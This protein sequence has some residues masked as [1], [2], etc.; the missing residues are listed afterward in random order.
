M[1]FEDRYPCNP[2]DLDRYRCVRVSGGKLRFVDMY[3]MNPGIDSHEKVTVW[4]LADPDSAKWTLEREASFSDIWADE[5]YEVTGLPKRTPG[6]A[7]IHPENPDVAYFFLA[8]HLFGVDLHARKVVECEVCD[9]Q[10]VSSSSLHA[11]ELPEGHSHQVTLPR[12]LF[13]G[14]VL[15]LLKCSSF[16]LHMHFWCLS[17]FS[18]CRALGKSKAPP[19]LCTRL[20]GV[21]SKV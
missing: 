13:L 2:S 15:C 16:H 9:Q 19:R 14:V 18:V 3:M 8:R 12:S 7:F 1:Q 20:Y 11:W 21:P 17:S 10:V 5:T 6:L 4:S